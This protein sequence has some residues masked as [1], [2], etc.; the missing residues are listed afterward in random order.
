MVIRALFILKLRGEVVK[1][2]KQNY[3]SAISNKHGFKLYLRYLS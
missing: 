2:L 3:L 1:V